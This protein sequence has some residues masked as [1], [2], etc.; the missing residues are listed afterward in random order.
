[1][2]LI[3][4][5]DLRFLKKVLPMKP[6]HAL[7]LFLLTA[8]LPAP[9][10]WAQAQN[11]AGI[12]TPSNPPAMRLIKSH[13]TPAYRAAQLFLR[14]ANLGDYLEANRRWRHIQITAQDFAEMKKEGFDHVRVP[15]GWHQY[16]GAA[17]EY[18]LEPEIFALV[19]FVVT[20]ALQNHLAVII[21]IHH[22]DALDQDPTN[23]MP[24]F[25][26]IWRQIAAHYQ[27]FPRQ[28]AFELDNEPHDRATTAVMNPIDARAIQEI[29]KTNRHR[30]LF[31]EPGGW[32]SIAELR[33]L[34][35]PPDD[36]IIVSV[37]C[38]DPF[39]FTHQ[40][41]TWTGGATP[42]TGIIFPGPPP[43]PLV[44]DPKL[45][46]KR[47]QTDWLNQYNR[48]PANQNPSSPLAFR[49]KLAY[50]RA[51]SDYYGRPIHLGEFGAYT[52]ADQASRVHFYSA[53]RSACEQEQI[54][55][56]IW[57]WNSG[58]HYWDKEHNCPAPGMHEALFG[59]GE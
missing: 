37:H 19:D 34:V 57:D 26:A 25:L 21:N 54:G 27:K 49:D 6:I 15:V 51:W 33:N 2:K 52:K 28:L 22:F 58:F 42:V 40:G 8:L 29:R 36:N 35:V 14:G 32:G 7:L 18:A 5:A 56:C 10:A 44:P 16:A 53:F 43:Q 38:Y 3:F 17:P 39:F 47:Y 4:P 55:W 23:A 9:R 50:I 45:Q 48:L 30:T 1:M 59:K 20:N 31:V 46:L 12:F 11:P 41:A 24:E 13:R